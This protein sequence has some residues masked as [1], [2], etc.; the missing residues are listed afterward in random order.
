MIRTAAMAILFATSFVT[1]ASEQASAKADPA[2]GKIVAETICVACHGADGNSMTSANPHLAGQIEQYIYKQL[3]NFKSV[4]G[5]PAAR[6]NAIMAGM[7]AALSDEDMK[8]VAAWFASQKLKPEAAKN[9]ASIALGKKL[10]RQGDFKKGIPACAGCHGPA[11]AG[12]P[13]QYPRLAGQFAEYTEA[14]LKA[15]RAEERGNDPEKMMRMIA[16]KLS[17]AEIKAVADYAA[18]LR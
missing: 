1:H 7:V 12:M 9:E 14:Q 10:W 17:D 2:K 16:A 13:A 8:N 15:F 3:T 4:D 6:D 11:G 18:G 5:K